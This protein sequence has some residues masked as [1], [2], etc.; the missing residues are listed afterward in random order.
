MGTTALAQAD[1]VQP[2]ACHLNRVD[3]ILL[4]LFLL[5]TVGLWR[6]WLLMSNLPKRPQTSHLVLQVPCGRDS[7]SSPADQAEGCHLH[8]G[9]VVPLS[10]LRCQSTH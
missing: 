4:L 5:R 9:G 3:A 8:V 6:R 1:V 7:T 10:D 2:F